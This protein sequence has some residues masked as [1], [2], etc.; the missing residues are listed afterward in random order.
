MKLE[1]DF[2]KNKQQSIA[3]IHKS[4]NSFKKRFNR[5]FFDMLQKEL[6]LYFRQLE[7]VYDPN[8]LLSYKP[9][10]LEKPIKEALKELYGEVG[11]KFALATYNNL[12]P[13][14][15]KAKNED[16]KEGWRNY[17][18]GY[19]D[20]HFETKI[21]SIANTCTKEVLR[22]SKET[23]QKGLLDGLGIEVIKDNLQRNLRLNNINR[24]RMIAQTEIIGASNMGSVIGAQ[25]VGIPLEKGW[26]TTTNKEVKTRDWHK[27]MN[28]KWVGLNE[29]FR[30]RNGR[31][32]VDLMQAAGDSTASASNVINCHCSIIYRRAFNSE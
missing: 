8:Q 17:M 14:K 24:A 15:T 28:G 23:I 21:E 12:E 19:I 4:R 11:S 26:I 32:G 29:P 10:I 20:L 7:S 18:Q 6:A 13:Q 3:N 22:L 30:V 1:G 16:L 27:E 2:L 31:G 9:V 5:L 25:A